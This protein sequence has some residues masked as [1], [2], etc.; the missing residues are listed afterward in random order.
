LIENER[1]IAETA[2][3]I[4]AAYRKWQ[5]ADAK[6]LNLSDIDLFVQLQYQIKELTNQADELKATIEKDL[7]ANEM[8]SYEHESGT[9][10]FMRRKSYDYPTEYTERENEFKTQKAEFDNYKKDLEAT[11]EPEVKKSL[12]F[13]AKY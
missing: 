2:Q 4:S 7:L 8:E 9:F 1:K 13:R 10:G 12:I 6:N 11:L 3:E 5:F